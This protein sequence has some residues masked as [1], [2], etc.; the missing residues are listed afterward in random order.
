[1][2]IFLKNT[3]TDNVGKHIPSAGTQATNYFTV[4]KIKL[5]QIPRMQFTVNTR[6]LL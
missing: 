2:F 6:M 3:I 5:E 4:Y 1:M